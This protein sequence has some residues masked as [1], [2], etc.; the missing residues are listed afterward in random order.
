MSEIVENVFE[1]LSRIIFRHNYLL[2]DYIFKLKN[3]II[4]LFNN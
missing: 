2:L 4:R 3:I 1:F